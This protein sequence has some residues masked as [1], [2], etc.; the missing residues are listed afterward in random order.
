MIQFNISFNV[1]RLNIRSRARSQAARNIWSIGHYQVKWFSQNS[2]NL[3]RN[4]WF[5]YKGNSFVI[6]KTFNIYFCFY[7]FINMREHYQNPRGNWESDLRRKIP[8]YIFQIYIEAMCG[9]YIYASVWIRALCYEYVNTS[10]QHYDFA[11]RADC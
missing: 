3:V 8:K 6:C 2:N 10:V 7:I 5:L 9:L 11:L 4:I 1:N